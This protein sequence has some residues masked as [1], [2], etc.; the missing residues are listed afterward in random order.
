M[1]ATSRSCRQC[2][3]YWPSHLNL[4][5]CP[6][7]N[8]QL[9]A[10][11]TAAMDSDE[12]ARRLMRAEFNR[13]YRD[14]WLTA[15]D[16]GLDPKTFKSWKEGTSLALRCDTRAVE[17]EANAEVKRRLSERRELEECWKTEQS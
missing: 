5:R 3:A 16:A 9:K 10:S 1:P 8:G 4:T 13:Y 17:R 11:V 14:E 15:H 7:C 12:A 2:E 6:E